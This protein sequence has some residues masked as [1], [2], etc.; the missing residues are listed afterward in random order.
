MEQAPKPNI[1]LT[2]FMGTGKTTVGQLLASRLSLEFIDTDVLIEMRSRQTVQAIFENLGEVH[3]RQLEREVAAELANQQGL[4]ISTGGRLMLDPEN[5]RLLGKN[6][7]IFCLVAAPEEILARI[8]NDPKGIER[9]LLQTNDPAQ[10]IVELLQ[11]RQVL[12]QHFPQISTSQRSPEE[13]CEA[14]L[15][16][17]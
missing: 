9:P 13:V 4:V 6:G 1:I 7:R 10:K 8:R 5:A 3:F 16:Q 15:G 14:I 2:G 11:K 17:L 12:Y